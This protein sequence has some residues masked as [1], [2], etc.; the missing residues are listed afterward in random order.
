MP[1]LR[2]LFQS[3]LREV[4]S[5]PSRQVMRWQLVF[6]KPLAPALQTIK[7]LHKDLKTDL[8]NVDLQILWLSFTA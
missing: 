1:S 5:N 6:I 7:E 2:F 3:G 4:F 8:D